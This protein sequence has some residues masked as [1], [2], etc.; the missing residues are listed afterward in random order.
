MRIVNA[1][2]VAVFAL[3][4]VNA[5]AQDVAVHTDGLLNNFQ[6]FS[7]GGGTDFNNPKPFH[8]VSGRRQIF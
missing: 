4:S 6:N 3:S 8:D 7:F 2:I 1:G 5:H